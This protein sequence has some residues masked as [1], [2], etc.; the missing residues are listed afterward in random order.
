MQMLRAARYLRLRVLIERPDVWVIGIVTRVFRMDC[1]IVAEVDSSDI[2]VID[3]HTRFLR[4]VD[5]ERRIVR[6]RS[7]IHLYRKVRS[8]P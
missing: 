1:H 3:E 2:I 5:A 7:L 8:Q 6:T 4:L